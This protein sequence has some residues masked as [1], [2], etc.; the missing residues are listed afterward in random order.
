MRFTKKYSE[1]VWQETRALLGATSFA[2]SSYA[3]SAR[4]KGSI[5]APEK[6][7]A[8]CASMAEGSPTSTYYIVADWLATRAGECTAGLGVVASR[9]RTCFFFSSASFF[10]GHAF[11]IE[12]GSTPFACWA[13]GTFSLFNL[14][15]RIFHIDMLTDTWEKEENK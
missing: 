14:R 10:S 1:E 2:S 11:E 7:Q 9:E 5:L 8:A 3:T 13:F 6:M 15:F 4:S 12:P